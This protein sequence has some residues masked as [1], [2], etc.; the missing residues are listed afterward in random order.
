MGKQQP[1]ERTHANILQKDIEEM[2]VR[3]NEVSIEINASPIPN[4]QID[5][6][7]IAR[8]RIE[9]IAERIGLILEN[10]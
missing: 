9:A 10:Y 6:W 1:F 8:S 3:V 2:M 5:E 7:N 4:L